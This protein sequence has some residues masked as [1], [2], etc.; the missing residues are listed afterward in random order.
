MDKNKTEFYH[1]RSKSAQIWTYTEDKILL[2]KHE[3]GLEDLA[4]TRG[5]KSI[6]NRQLFLES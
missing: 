5:P 6:Q 1:S 2:D 4:N 3:R